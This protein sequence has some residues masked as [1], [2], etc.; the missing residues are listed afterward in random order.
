MIMKV[1]NDLLGYNSCK[2]VQDTRY[3]SFSLDSVI[4][5]NY[6]NI[7]KKTEKILDIG[8]GNAP[9]P[10]ILSIKY[11]SNASIYGFELQKEIF[12]LAKESVKI[13]DLESRIS[14]IND[15]IK[16]IDKYFEKKTFD[17]IVSNPPYFK[18][19]LNS[20]TN[21]EKIKTIARHEIM[22]N[23]DDLIK[24]SYQYL[25]DR[26]KF[27][28]VHRT[29]R[30]SEIITKMHNNKIEPKRIL[31]IFPKKDSSSNL[32]I[33]E[34]VKN[35]KEGIRELKQIIAHNS[36]GSYTDEIIKF[37]SDN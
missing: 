16:N 10:I 26:G 3:F 20:K 5:A 36:D 24:I 11:N 32:F 29:E 33:V 22:L 27:L 2:I 30:M 19:N 13:N 15:D 35:G 14:L 4:L 25:K 12:N 9:I 17:I 18:Y 23:I 8:T 1:V 34:G 6:I 37:F 21:D 31:F 7:D 28:I